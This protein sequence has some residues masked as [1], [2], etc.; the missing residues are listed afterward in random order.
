MDFYRDELRRQLKAVDEEN[1]AAMKPW[2]EALM[3]I[4]VGGERAPAQAKARLIGAPD[5]RSFL[6]VGGLTVAG[7]AFLAACGSSTKG[8]QSGTTLP[9]TTT[10]V[11]APNT[12]APTTTGPPTADEKKTDLG[13]LRTSTSL[14]LLAVA[15]YGEAEPL[16]KSVELRATA[17]LFAR[18]H[19]EHAQQLQAATSEG[20]GAKEVYKKPN[21]VLKK[22]LVDLELPTLL[23]DADIVRFAMSLEDTAAATY[24][25][26]AGE[27]SSAKLRQA[28][29]A[30]GGIEARHAAILAHVLNTPVPTDALWST[31]DS[32]SSDAF[33]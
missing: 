14:E 16:L 21:A 8:S 31:Q 25:S 4:F 33:V 17:R 6:R 28:I 26:A 20:F 27:L 19:R 24:V 11:G 12:D 29:M 2:R 13:L 22:N 10:A 30:I 23:T 32:V 1:T 18:Q 9:S 7:S 15:V 3:R 5:R